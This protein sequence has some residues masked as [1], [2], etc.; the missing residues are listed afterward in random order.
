MQGTYNHVVQ[1]KNH[2][3]RKIEITSPPQQY[4]ISPVNLW[5]DANTCLNSILEEILL[6]KYLTKRWITVLLLKNSLTCNLTPPSIFLLYRDNTIKCSAT[7]IINFFYQCTTF[8]FQIKCQ[9]GFTHM[10]IYYYSEVDMHTLLDI[11]IRL[12]TTLSYSSIVINLPQ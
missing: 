10:T 12:F 8:S 5:N 2:A 9:P 11:I 1:L 6:M 3:G 4:I 7:L